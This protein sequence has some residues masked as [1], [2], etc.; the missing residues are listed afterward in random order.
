MDIASYMNI[1]DI[2]VAIFWFNRTI[3]KP[4]ELV[5]IAS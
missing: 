3:V 1:V 2:Q 5:Y 4:P